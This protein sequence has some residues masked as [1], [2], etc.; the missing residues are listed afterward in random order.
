MASKIRS[1]KSLQQDL[2]KRSQESYDKKDDSGRYGTFFKAKSELGDKEFWKCG[3]GEHQIDIIPWIAGSNYPSK[4][5][6]IKEG[7]I[8]IVL[9]IWIHYN[10]GPNEDS[11]VCP[12]R[13]YGK[14]CPI[15]EHINEIRKRDDLDEDEIKERTKEKTPKR[16]SIYQIVCYDSNDEE[17]KGVQ[18]WDVAHF[19]ME[20]HLTEL[21]QKP[22]RGG[23]IAYADPDEGKQ[24]YFK[25]KGQGQFN[26]EYMAHQFLDREYII[27]DAILDSTISLDEAVVVLSYNELKR[28]YWGSEDVPATGPTEE[29]EEQ[30]Q[31][32]TTRP[33]RKPPVTDEDVKAGAVTGDPDIEPEQQE[34]EQPRRRVRKPAQKEEDKKE[35]KQEQD[36]QCPAGGVF[37]VDIDKPL[38]ECDDCK[39]WDDCARE[40]ERLEKEGK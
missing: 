2:L 25:R 14:P 18:I 6:D 8:A 20:R 27:D 13:N 30:E 40:A 35:D 22:K 32:K 7:D 4:S 5:Y 33:A 9:D 38:P 26:T 31:P 21:S 29:E 24:V 16:R 39:V 12:A 23:F 11:V 28:K 1:R 37:G 3:E 36:N 17:N 34:A 15:C 10:V 19:F